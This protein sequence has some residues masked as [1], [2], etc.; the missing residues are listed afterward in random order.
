MLERFSEVFVLSE[1][2]LRFPIFLI[3]NDK[4]LLLLE[5]CPLCYLVICIVN[6][7]IVTIR[8]V[9]G[10]CLR[11]PIFTD[12]IVNITTITFQKFVIT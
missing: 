3:D 5:R 9:F 4:V 2:L 7:M 10:G 11:A 6:N 8:V 12:V 1:L